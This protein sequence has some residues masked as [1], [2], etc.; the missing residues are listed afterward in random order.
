[1]GHLDE[2]AEPFGERMVSSDRLHENAGAFHSKGASLD[3][4]EKQCRR[5][6]GEAG[7][8]GRGRGVLCPA[9]ELS[10]PFPVRFRPEIACQ[11]LGSRDD[12]TVRTTG[13]DVIDRLVIPCD[14]FLDRRASGETRK[15]V[16]THADIDVTCLARGVFEQTRELSLGLLEGRVRHVVDEG[17]FDD[18]VTGSRPRRLAGLSP[19]DTQVR[20]V[21]ATTS[22]IGSSPT[23][24]L[25]GRP[26]VTLGHLWCGP[27]PSC[28]Q[29][30]P[31]RWK[32]VRQ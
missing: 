11:R 2:V 28:P 14:S 16:L 1:M 7:E 19:S 13:V 27:C 24:T 15:P 29:H 18:R 17:N 26:I 6:S 12:E 9:D 22:E 8:Q 4:V 20:L 5:M 30:R 10:Q 23:V 25:C 21:M 3:A 31:D 32:T